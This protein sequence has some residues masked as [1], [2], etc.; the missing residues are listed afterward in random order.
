MDV[1]AEVGRCIKCKEP[2]YI[3]CSKCY[4]ILLFHDQLHN[5]P[6]PASNNNDDSLPPVEICDSCEKKMGK[7]Q[8]RKCF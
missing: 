7:Q 3:E 1:A 8:H 4:C 5:C 2:C 6:V